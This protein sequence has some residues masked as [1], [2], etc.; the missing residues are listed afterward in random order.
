MQQS[1]SLPVGQL[2]SGLGGVITTGVPLIFCCC[3]CCCCCCPG[4]AC[5]VPLCSKTLSVC[6]LISGLCRH[7]LTP[8]APLV[9]YTYLLPVIP[10]RVT[11]CECHLPVSTLPQSHPSSALDVA[12][13]ERDSTPSPTLST[14][15]PFLSGADPLTPPP[16]PTHTKKIK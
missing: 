8:G 5:L 12:L 11:V 3:C 10:C 6:Q 16:P 1:V 14:P 7:V 4:I 15:N 9:F 2:I 13:R